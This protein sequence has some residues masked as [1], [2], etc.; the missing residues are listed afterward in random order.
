MADKAGVMALRDLPVDRNTCLF[1]LVWDFSGNRRWAHRRSA[2][3]SIEQGEL[4]IHVS[5]AHGVIDAVAGI[6]DLVGRNAGQ[7]T[8]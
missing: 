4:F 6:H 7:L 8:L 2:R 5:S 1:L 3:D